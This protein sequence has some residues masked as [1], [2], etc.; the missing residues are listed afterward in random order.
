M[1]LRKSLLPALLIVAATSVVAANSELTVDS[2]DRDIAAPMYPTSKKLKLDKIDGRHPDGVRG[3]TF[4]SYSEPPVRSGL[5]Q[6]PAQEVLRRYACNSDV[7]GVAEVEDSKSFVGKNENGVFTKLRFK[8]VDSW[9]VRPGPKAQTFQLIV[10]GG[11]VEYKGEIIRI[12][13]SQGSYIK[14]RRYL[15]ILA[16]DRS[17]TVDQKIF[18]GDP[19]LLE[20]SNGIIYP[21]PGWSPFEPGTSLIRAQALVQES[22]EPKG[23][24]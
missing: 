8:L 16:G 5:M 10:V 22:L 3:L 21:A 7:F 12:S 1:F 9:R 15:M 18:A 6:D 13:N 23:C 17:E 11:E 24:E 20:V 14:G 4:F 2:N 19:L